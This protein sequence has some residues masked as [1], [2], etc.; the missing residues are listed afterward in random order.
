MILYNRR[1]RQAFFA[2]QNMMLQAKLAEAK[3]TLATGGTVDEDQMLLLDREKIAQEAEAKRRERKGFWELVKQGFSSQGLKVEEDSD[4]RAGSIESVGQNG[5]TF[6]L[7]T[8][9]ELPLVQQE[10]SS[11]RNS[12]LKSVE[13]TRRAGEKGLE[14]MGVRGGPL[15]QLADGDATITNPVA[16]ETKSWLGWLTGR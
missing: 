10:Q 14:R 6:N 9:E 13:E 15:D 7:Q 4:V 12:V 3:E 2:E 1:K 8:S 16:G 5:E 11:R